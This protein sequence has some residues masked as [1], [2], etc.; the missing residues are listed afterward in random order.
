MRDVDLRGRAPMP[1]GDAKFTEIY[2][3]YGKQIQAYCARR[4]DRSQVADAVAETF[5]VAWRRLDQIDDV[6]TALPWLYG[7]AYR[8]I[9][10]QWRS[11]SR[12]RALARRLRNVVTVEA[13]TTDAVEVRQEQTDLVVLATSRLKAIDQEVLRLELWEGL[14]HDEVAVALDIR[15]DAARQRMSRARRNLT[16]EYDKLVETRRP[17]L[18]GGGVT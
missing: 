9:C 13:E 5:L 12:A 10:H 14:S 18:L 16:R 2:S 4:I 11:E 3:R 15:P 17:R 1:S 8:V 6:N 7:T